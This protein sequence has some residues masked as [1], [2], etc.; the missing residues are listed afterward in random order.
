MIRAMTNVRRTQASARLRSCS[1]AGLLHR[2]WTD[3]PQRPGGWLCSWN[4]LPVLGDQHENKRRK[5]DTPQKP[6][7]SGVGVP[8]EELADHH[9][10]YAA[11]DR[12]D[13]TLD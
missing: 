4:S 6:T 10:D 11:A 13:E 8:V 5:A 2:R 3:Q 1:I 7:A 12:L 9:A